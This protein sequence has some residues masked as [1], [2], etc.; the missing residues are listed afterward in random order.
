MGLATDP[1][2]V[3]WTL[4]GYDPPESGGHYFLHSEIQ[5]VD[6]RR[7]AEKS[8]RSSRQFHALYHPETGECCTPVCRGF[9]VLH[10]HEQGQTCNQLC[11]AYGEEVPKL[12]TR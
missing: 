9:R 12:A 1:D 5:T 3:P 4:G 2:W 10:H 6:M 7:M 11:E 8:Y